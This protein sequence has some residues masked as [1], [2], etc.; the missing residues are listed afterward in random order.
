ML[1]SS[2][3]KPFTWSFSKLKNFETCALRYK[4]IDVEKS[5]AQPRGEA[6]ERGDELHDA[7]RIRV[8]GNK[9][10]P[11]HLVY[12]EPWGKKLTTVL[13]PLQII[14][15]ELKL[16]LSREGKP[17][18]YFEKATWFRTKIDYLRIMPTKIKD[19]DF[20]H[21]VDYKTGRPPKV[22]DGTQLTLNAWTIFQHYGYVQQMRVDYLWSEYNDTSHETYT[23][24]EMPTLIEAL[25]PRVNA[26]EEAHKTN[27]FPPK[28]N[29]LCAE[30]CDVVT[31]QFHGKRMGRR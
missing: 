14:Q 11:P 22:W 2:R 29:G 17:T 30:Y 4:E 26:L 7:M 9:P 12:M 31:C 18:G 20:A 23:R 8:Q 5:V 1:D 13:H 16:S 28:P 19:H 6:L 25:L 24:D 3:P 15:C 21:V 10:L 27:N